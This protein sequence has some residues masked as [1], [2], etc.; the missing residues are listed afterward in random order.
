VSTWEATA[1]FDTGCT[2]KDFT[3]RFKNAEPGREDVPYQRLRPYVDFTNDGPPPG[4]PSA[5][6]SWYAYQGLKDEQIGLPFYANYNGYPSPEKD[7]AASEPRALDIGRVREVPILANTTQVHGG[8]TQ[9]AVVPV[10]QV[11][12]TRWLGGFAESD[13]NAGCRPATSENRRRM[14]PT[15]FAE[16]EDWRAA[17]W[18]L[19]QA[20]G[21]LFGFVPVNTAQ[22]FLTDPTCGGR[23]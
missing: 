11:P 18:Y 2:P 15:F 21:K 20:P 22:T 16:G 7:S 4:W 1:E 19:I 9:R 14:A 8:G 12:Y 3:Q 5:F 17:R 6:Q 13:P 23:G 10:D